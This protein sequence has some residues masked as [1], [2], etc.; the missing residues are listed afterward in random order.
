MIQTIEYIHSKKIIHR[1]LKP[2]H[3]TIGNQDKKNKIFI[4]DFSYAKKYMNSNDEHIESKEGKGLFGT[5][6]YGSINCHLGLELSRRD[7]LESLGYIFVYFLKGIVP[8][9]CVKAKSIKEKYQKIKD[10]KI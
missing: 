8:W 1:D 2:G 10:L 7:D 5:S 4:I 6:R 9:S 3:F